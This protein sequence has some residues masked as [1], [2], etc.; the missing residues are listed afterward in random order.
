MIVY[1]LAIASFFAVIFV[2]KQLMLRNRALTRLERSILFWLVMIPELAMSVLFGRRNEI[3]DVVI[4]ALATSVIA[5]SC[6]LAGTLIQERK[7]TL[8]H[9]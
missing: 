7:T 4:A 9:H 3:V 8:T 1:L 5:G 2:G 6:F